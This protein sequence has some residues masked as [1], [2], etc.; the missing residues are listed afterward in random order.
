MAV[1]KE[2]IDQ[3]WKENVVQMWIVMIIWFLVSYGAAF[4]APSL[5]KITFLGFPLGYYMGAQGAITTFV[6]LNWYYATKMSKIEEKYGLSEE[7]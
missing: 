4:F 5:N 2:T 1:S 7:G 3:Y 6:I